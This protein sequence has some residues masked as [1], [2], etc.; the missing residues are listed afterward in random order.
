MD[1]VHHQR[2]LP[3]GSQIGKSLAFEG[4][5]LSE[6]RYLSGRDLRTRRWIKVVFALGKPL[7]TLSSPLPFVA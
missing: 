5:P 4:F 1:A 2:G 7:D 6:C 3:N